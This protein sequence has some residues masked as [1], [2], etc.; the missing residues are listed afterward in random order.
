MLQ[1]VVIVYIDTDIVYVGKVL[2]CYA[3][4]V[5][6]LGYT[7]CLTCYM[8]NVLH[9]IRLNFFL[10]DNMHC[11]SIEGVYITLHSGYDSM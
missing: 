10:N 2:S 8:H 4:L 1:F 5:T 9:Y 6:I 3:T 7:A 11:H